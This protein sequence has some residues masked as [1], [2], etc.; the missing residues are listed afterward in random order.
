MHLSQPVLCSRNQNGAH[1]RGEIL[2]RLSMSCTFLVTAE[3]WP[4]EVTS[5]VYLRGVASNSNGCWASTPTEN[6]VLQTVLSLWERR[7]SSELQDVRS[8][9]YS[10]RFDCYVCPQCVLYLNV[11]VVFVIVVFLFCCCFLCCIL[12][13][14][15]SRNFQS[16]WRVADN[17]RIEWAFGENSWKLGVP[18][19]TPRCAGDGNRANPEWQRAVSCNQ[20]EG[21]SSPEALEG[22]RRGQLQ[23]VGEGTRSWRPGSTCWAVLRRAGDCSVLLFYERRK[24]VERLTLKIHSPLKRNV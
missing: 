14:F 17:R 22:P 24:I 6:R 16:H 12:T 11:V 23:S 4:M 19:K 15:R 20:T 5:N 7:M 2:S 9:S 10:L 1:T 18:G 13:S 8:H 3:C 21:V